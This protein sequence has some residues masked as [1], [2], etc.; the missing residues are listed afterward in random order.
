MA[1][2]NE[3]IADESMRSAIR[4]M[5]DDELLERDAPELSDK[6]AFLCRAGGMSLVATIAYLEAAR[7]GRSARELMVRWGVPSE[8]IVMLDE[9]RDDT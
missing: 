5:F 7:T 3:H 9:D 1:I 4:D 2:E 8:Y 6:E